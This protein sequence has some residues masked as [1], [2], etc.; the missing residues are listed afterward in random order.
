MKAL[1]AFASTSASGHQ[2]DPIHGRM[3]VRRDME[4]AFTQ[5]IADARQAVIASEAV[6]EVVRRNAVSTENVTLLLD[7]AKTS[8]QCADDVIARARGLL[9]DVVSAPID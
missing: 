7:R 8:L 9:A 3:A 5:L 4:L 1:S 6:L 2:Q